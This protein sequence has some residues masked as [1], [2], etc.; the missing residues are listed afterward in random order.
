MID[1][2]GMTEWFMVTVLKTV[3]RKYQGFESLSLRQKKIPHASWV[4][5]SGEDH[6]S[7]GENQHGAGTIV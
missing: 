3:V 5:S 7:S 2:G 4:F 6:E 1:Y